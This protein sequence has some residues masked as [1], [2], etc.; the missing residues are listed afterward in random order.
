MIYRQFKHVNGKLKT[1]DEILSELLYRTYIIQSIQIRFVFINQLFFLF[2]SFTKNA[3][4][5]DF[6]RVISYDLCE[7]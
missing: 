1:T 4:A 6:S 7:C 2:H 5:V 3:S